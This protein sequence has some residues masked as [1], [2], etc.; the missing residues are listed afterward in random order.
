MNIYINEAI[1]C[2]TT[3]EG[4]RLDNNAYSTIKHVLCKND[5][6]LNENH[7]KTFCCVVD[8]PKG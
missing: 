7:N 1:A 3:H 5:L 4:A 8:V 6:Q 2:R